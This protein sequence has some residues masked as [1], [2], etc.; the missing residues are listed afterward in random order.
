[1]RNIG[2]M[3]FHWSV[4]S[5]KNFLLCVVI[6]YIDTI[7]M[8]SN[9]Q[10]IETEFDLRNPL[11]SMF[12]LLEHL[13]LF[14]LFLESKNTHCTLLTTHNHEFSIRR[15]AH[16]SAFRTI[17]EIVCFIIFGRLNPTRLTF[18]IF[19]QI[20]RS[21]RLQCSVLNTPTS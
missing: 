7:I 1:M 2:R 21:D 11:L 9:Y 10:E 16:T 14:S 20:Q 17:I 5:L 13:H 18:R 19:N 4:L 8:R 12:E 15:N 6:I 3:F